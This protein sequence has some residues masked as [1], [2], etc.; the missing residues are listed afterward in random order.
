MNCLKNI[1]SIRKIDTCL[2]TVLTIKKIS[3][4]NGNQGLLN[5]KNLGSNL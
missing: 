1:F 2:K 3:K 4:E 5:L